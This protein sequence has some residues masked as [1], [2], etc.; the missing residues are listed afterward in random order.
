M[1][2]ANRH[3]ESQTNGSRLREISRT[4]QNTV[5]MD[6]ERPTTLVWLLRRFACPECG[7]R[8]LDDHPEMPSNRLT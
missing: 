3:S 4:K 2:S 8:H 1:M 5:P 7:E 6:R